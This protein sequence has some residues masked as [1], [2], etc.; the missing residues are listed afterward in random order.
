MHHLVELALPIG[1]RT[2]SQIPVAGN[3]VGREIESHRIG[4]RDN[5]MG[6][7][8]QLAL[9]RVRV[10]FD[11]SIAG[12][13]GV[14]VL[15]FLFFSV[16]VVWWG[17]ADGPCCVGC[18]AGRIVFELFSDVVPKTAENFRALCTGGEESRS[19]SLSLYPLC[20]CVRLSGRRV[21]G[22]RGC[23]LLSFLM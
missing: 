17:L 15:Q 1:T 5:R 13:Q 20:V 7:D 4:G 11:V 16:A 6:K 3:R 18:A 8:K 23:I 12:E 2:E 14:W 22:C 9:Q 19:L 21:V 10:F